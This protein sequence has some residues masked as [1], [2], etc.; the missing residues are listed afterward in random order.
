[1]KAVVRTGSSAVNADY[2]S[3]ASIAVEKAPPEAR[4]IGGGW[5]V[6][7]ALSSIAFQY[8]EHFAM[9]GNPDAGEEAFLI[10]ERR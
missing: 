1:M 3:N 4:G 9:S 7:Y 5:D 6:R 2:L 8:R 10:A